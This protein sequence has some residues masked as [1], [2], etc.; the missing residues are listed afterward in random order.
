MS[1]P[2]NP[3]FFDAPHQ[4]V[5]NTPSGVPIPDKRSCGQVQTTALPPHVRDLA[6]LLAQIAADEFMQMKAAQN[7]QGQ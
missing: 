2:Q 1:S 3:H 6:E 7:Q 5:G 4:K